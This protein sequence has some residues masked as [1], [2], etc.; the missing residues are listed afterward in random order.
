MLNK[1]NSIYN[2]SK[3][4][5][6]YYIYMKENIQ[7]LNSQFF[8]EIKNVLWMIEKSYIFKILKVRVFYFFKSKLKIKIMLL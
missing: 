4:I 3:F 8:F 1:N 6:Q 5:F 7:S 2:Y